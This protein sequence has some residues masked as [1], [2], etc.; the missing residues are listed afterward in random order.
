MRIGIQSG[1]YFGLD[2]YEK[3]LSLMKAH[4]F[5]ATDLGWFANTETALFTCTVSE[6]EAKLK[7]LRAA[8]DGAG[9]ELWQA[10]GPWRYPP[11]DFEEADRAERY[12]KMAKSLY[13]CAVL[14]CPHLVIHPLMPYG[15]RK[16]PDPARFYEINFEH[17]SRL[18]EEAKKQGVILCI[19]NM[20]MPYLSLARTW[21]LL[22]FV[23]E[24]D[25]DHF[26]I[27]LDTG[28]AALFG[29]PATDVRVLGKEYLRVMHVHDN[30][31]AHDQHLLPYMGV[32]DWNL[33]TT[34]LREIG[35]DGV[36]MLETGVKGHF[37]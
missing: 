5:D 4:G 1:T 7:A 6:Y 16:D 21:D 34:A 20:P 2:N 17:F 32:V 9:V 3:G 28:H 23:K 25:N 22:R 18:A 30:D 11:K 33:Y 26:R 29:Q 36:F 24:V 27:C 19:E 14:G 10:H 15:D 13:G 35:Y 31:G 8:A 12:E 37:P